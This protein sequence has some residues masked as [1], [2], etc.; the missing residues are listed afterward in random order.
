MNF[1]KMVAVINVVVIPITVAITVSGMPHFTVKAPSAF[2]K[3]QNLPACL[4]LGNPCMKS[5]L[6]CCKLTYQNSYLRLGEV[7]TTCFKF[8]K[9]ICQVNQSI[10]NFNEYSK[11]IE[12]VND[13]NFQELKNKYWLSIPTVYTCPQKITLEMKSG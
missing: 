9:G 10:K 13:T 12:Q 6:P 3:L 1:W 7:P 5:K 4:P 2:T 8:G 11:L